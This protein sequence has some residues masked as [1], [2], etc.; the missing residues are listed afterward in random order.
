M[1]LSFRIQ[2]DHQI[3]TPA[4]STVKDTIEAN[5]GTG[6]EMGCFTIQS[7]VDL[8]SAASSTS[9]AKRKADDNDITVTNPHLVTA[10]SSTSGAKR[11]AGNN[12]ISVPTTQNP[13]QIKST[14][15]TA[16][17]LQGKKPSV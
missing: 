15:S 9:N 12:D 8:V 13:D 16:S 4:A 7:L 17:S 11:K 1:T 14:L 2:I 6:N 10:A 3:S 5:S